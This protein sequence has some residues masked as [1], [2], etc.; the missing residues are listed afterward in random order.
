MATSHVGVIGMRLTGGCQH[1]SSRVMFRGPTSVLVANST[2]QYKIQVGVFVRMLG[3]TH[4]WRVVA[5]G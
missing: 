2:A 1:Q 3:N 5:L 4:V